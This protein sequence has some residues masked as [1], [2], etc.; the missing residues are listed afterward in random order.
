MNRRAAILSTTA[1]LAA[2][3]AAAPRGAFAQGATTPE[4]RKAT[5][6]Y[7][8]LTDSAPLIIAKEKGIFAKYGMPD[9]EVSKQASWGA[10]RDNLVLGGGAGGI[11]GAHLLTPM[12]YMIHT[13]RIVQNNQPV[14]MAILARLNT[15]GQGISVAAKHA[16]LGAKLDAS[17][18]RRALTP[19]SKVAMT[20]RGGT[21]DLWIRY[22]M[23][24]AGI[25]PD[26]DVSTIVVPPPQMVA[27]MRVGTMDAFCVGEPWN[28][29]L[30]AQRLG[31]TAAITGEIWKNHPEKAFALRASFVEQNP[32]ATQALTAA[33]LEAAQWCDVPGNKA[34]MASI[35]GRRAWFNVPASDIQ[36]RLQG[37]VDYGDG[38]TVTN[39][40]LTMKFWRDHASYPFQSHDLWFLTENIRWGVIPA[41]TDTRALVAQVNKEQLWRQAAERA[42]VAAS[43][44]PTGTSRGTET[45]FD[46]KVFDPEN[47]SAYLASLSIKRSGGGA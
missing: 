36:P 29:Q 25:D 12:A 31:Y 34:E 47:P 3:R 44:T 4:V 24:A 18:L 8:A 9:V 39:L 20:F 10:T 22:W 7:I 26:R 23:A 5:L 17:P 28:A 42:G 46:G 15:N 41:D 32:N 35:L 37:I 30:V 13:G 16:A 45:F 6:G 19:E 1:L 43:A 33:V 2:A 14:P 11:D 27:N 38:R 21:H 40:D